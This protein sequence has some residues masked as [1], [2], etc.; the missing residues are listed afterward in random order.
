MCSQ[1]TGR[2]MMTARKMLE[3]AQNPERQLQLQRAF[4]GSMTRTGVQSEKLT[5]TKMEGN[6]REITA[7]VKVYGK[8]ITERENGRLERSTEAL[9]DPHC[10]TD[11]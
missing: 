8:N 10:F 4:K 3:K 5:P 6:Q 9:W 11:C 7:M 2:K 1:T